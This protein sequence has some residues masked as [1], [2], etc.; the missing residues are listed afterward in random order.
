MATVAKAEETPAEVETTEAPAEGVDVQAATLAALT[1][2]ADAV[3]KIQQ[4]TGPRSAASGPIVL[5]VAAPKDTSRKITLR[6][7]KEALEVPRNSAHVLES[8]GWTRGAGS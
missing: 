4:G 8:L 1:S 2:L 5:A 7:G 3:A 6:N